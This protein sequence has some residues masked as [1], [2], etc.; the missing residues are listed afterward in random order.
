MTENGNGP[1]ESVVQKSDSSL[2]RSEIDVEVERILKWGTNANVQTAVSL[3]AVNRDGLDS[4]SS[5]LPSPE[6][7][8]LEGNS[9]FKVGQY[10]KAIERYSDCLALDPNNASVWSN[11]SLSNIRLKRFEQALL[12]AD[13]AVRL[14]EKYAK[15]IHRRGKALAGLNRHEEAVRDFEK[16]IRLEPDEKQIFGDLETS[17]KHVSCSIIDPVEQKITHIESN[18]VRVAVAEEGESNVQ[19]EPKNGGKTTLNAVE[20]TKKIGIDLFYNGNIIGAIKMFTK[21]IDDCGDDCPAILRST[22]YSNRSLG[23]LKLNQF[24]QAASD[25]RLALDFD[26]DSFKGAYRAAR[27]LLELGHLVEALEMISTAISIHDRLL[28]VPNPDMEALKISINTKRDKISQKMPFT[29]A[30]QDMS[31]RFVPKVP[32][33]PPKTAYEFFTTWNSLRSHP[34][35]LAGYVRLL[36]DSSIKQCFAHSCVEPDW[37]TDILKILVF[38]GGIT[39]YEDNATRVAILDALIKSHR[40]ETQFRMLSSE[41]IVCLKETVSTLTCRVSSESNERILAF[42]SKL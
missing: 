14:D 17:K 12:D 30:T 28:G 9:Y 13:Q 31:S 42:V 1:N 22:I 39:D 10:H 21:A 15:A 34:E 4:C 2:T 7:L 29:G 26:P 8:K 19:I 24:E 27:A 38:S 32:D 16:A 11:R 5:N 35:R 41:E 37:L 40:A 20:E 23:H 6:D 25:G 36:T 18:F 33:K 3:E